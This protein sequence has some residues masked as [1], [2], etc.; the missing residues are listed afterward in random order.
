MRKKVLLSGVLKNDSWSALSSRLELAREF[1]PFTR[2]GLLVAIITS[3]G[4][5]YYGF[6][7]HDLVWYV[8]ALSG[9]GLI[10]LALLSV[11][12]GSIFIN[13][14]MPNLASK[15]SQK[16]TADVP[17]TSQ[18]I[19]PR[20]RFFPLLDTQLEW[21]DPKGSLVEISFDDGQARE[22]IT[23]VEHGDFTQAERRITVTDVFG[24]A[25]LTI[26]Y[27]CQ[28][29][30]AVLPN[31]GRLAMVPWLAS[32]NDGEDLPH[33]SGAAVGDR[34]ELRPYHAGDPA[35]FIHWKAFA[36]TRK[37]MQREPERSLSRTHRTAAYLVAGL[38][39]GASAAA[40]LAVLDANALGIDWV[41]GADGMPEPLSSKNDV[42]AAIRQSASQRARGGEDLAN[43]IACVDQGGA[44]NLMLFV[45][46]CAGA[47][48][49]NV[50]T[51]LAQSNAQCKLVIGIDGFKQRPR[52]SSWSEWWRK[53]A[54]QSAPS[55]SLDVHALDQLAGRLETA[56]ATVLI[57][58]RISGRLLSKKDLVAQMASK[59]NSKS[60]A[61]SL[62]R[63][64]T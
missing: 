33:P 7:Q 36:R 1:F 52:Y 13:K 4:F 28:A 25:S 35:R 47:W 11:L 6:A 8:G 44:F 61:E 5:W 53:F 19:L 15:L 46:S 60:V 42:E 12:V 63:K 2:L 51:V 27:T 22:Q 3:L 9:L 49:T 10:F 45:P 31:R 59:H 29:K 23:L 34:L 32:L 18:F 62:A 56:G 37:L 64:A 24:L 58:D 20:L 43:F 55:T 48:E 26:R 17:W 30:L 57:T 16:C 38:G 21:A 40:A 14:S 41:F 54:I 39:D 50:M